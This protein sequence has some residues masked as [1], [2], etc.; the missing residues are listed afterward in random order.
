MI[1]QLDI[2]SQVG[3][4]WSMTDSE[5]TPMLMTQAAAPKEFDELTVCQRQQSKCASCSCKCVKAGLLCSPECG[6][7]VDSD[8]CENT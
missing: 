5:L 6:C 8:L 3:Y 1:A 4:G 2:E 7:E